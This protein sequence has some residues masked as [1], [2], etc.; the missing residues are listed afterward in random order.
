MRWD[1]M[2][3]AWRCPLLARVS[4]RPSE[5]NIRRREP[6][7]APSLHGGTG[8]AQCPRMTPKL[9]A[10]AAL[11]AISVLPAISRAYEP[12]EIF[13]VYDHYQAGY[14]E[15]YGNDWFYDYYEFDADGAGLYYAY[16]SAFDYGSD[17]FVWE[18]EGLFQ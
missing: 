16:Y 6:P 8:V 1:A 12:D 18:E 14:D 7:D 5:P 3:T 17:L 11:A 13:F 10:V 15:S 2:D 4:A 9:L